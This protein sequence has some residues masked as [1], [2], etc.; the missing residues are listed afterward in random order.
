[1]SRKREWMYTM[2]LNRD[3]GFNLEFRQ[4]VN[5]FLDFAYTNATNI[6]PVIQKGVR[7]FQIRCPCKFCKNRIYNKREIVFQHL[8]TDG[9]V[10][11][12]K[13]WHAHGELYSTR[14]IRQSSNPVPN[15]I[16]LII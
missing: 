16:P 6:K 2:R 3:G 14:E 9:F 7:V 8:C 12:Y 10:K 5:E 15:P 4:Y 11:D 13:L 1:M